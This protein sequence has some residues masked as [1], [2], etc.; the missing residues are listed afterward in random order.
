MLRT[1]KHQMAILAAK[2]LLETNKQQNLSTAKRL[3][4]IIAGAYIF[5]KGISNI[6]KHPVVSA[7]E[8]LVG[9]FL[10]YDA[11]RGIQETY[12]FRPK[13][14]SE[15]RRNQIQGNDPSSASPAFV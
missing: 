14:T 9:G 13:E 10:I 3:V 6:F 11:V 12:P 2:K 4:S 8:V 15:V 7:Q 5:Q 1:A